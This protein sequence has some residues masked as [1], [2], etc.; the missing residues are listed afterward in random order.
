MKTRT[1]LSGRVFLFFGLVFFLA[2][3]GSVPRRGPLY[4]WAN[5]EEQVFAFL[6]GTIDRN[7][8][9]YAMEMDLEKIIASGR[10]VPPGY[11]AH[12][13]LLSAELGFNEKAV[14]Y[15]TMEKFLFPEAAFFMDS[16][17]VRY[18]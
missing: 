10:N 7:V 17:L 3:C 15:F 16:L 8:Q 2:A 12:L 14:S 9:L 1:W 6:D 18:R 13:G 5:Y 11:Y 4:S